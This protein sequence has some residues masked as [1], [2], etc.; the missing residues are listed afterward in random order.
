MAATRKLRRSG[1]APCERQLRAE[2]VILVPSGAELTSW[3]S[4]TGRFEPKAGLVRFAKRS[5][6]TR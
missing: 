2:H 6:R 3:F 1:T 4:L 5:L